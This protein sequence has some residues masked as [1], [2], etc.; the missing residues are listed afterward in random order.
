MFPLMNLT[1]APCIAD[2]NDYDVLD[3]G[4]RI[5]RVFLSPH[6]PVG[7]PWFWGIFPPPAG[8]EG[9][10]ATR[11]EAMSDLS[12][13]FSTAQLADHSR[14]RVSVSVDQAASLPVQGKA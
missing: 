5:G 11:E 4:R 9:Y 13:R 6:A 12:H 1:L 8:N 2:R 7:H 10:A 14:G 3:D